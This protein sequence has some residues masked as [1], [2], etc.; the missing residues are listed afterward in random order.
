[1][2]LQNGVPKIALGFVLAFVKLN[3]SLQI[4][5]SATFLIC[6]A[7][8]CGTVRAAKSQE[9]GRQNCSNEQN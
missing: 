3:F 5:L 4:Y 2:K 1:M 7:C 9:S 8:N 6:F